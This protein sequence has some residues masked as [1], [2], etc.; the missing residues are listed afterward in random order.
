MNGHTDYQIISDKRGKPAFVVIPYEDFQK[1]QSR[2]KD[3]GSTFPNEV[4]GLHIMEN[5]SLLCAWREHKGLTTENM[6]KRM[7]LSLAEYLEIEQSETIP[8]Q[9]IDK[10]AEFLGID[11]ALLSADE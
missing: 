10:A 2:F 1:I 4:V 8:I 9:Y 6:A 11:P 5:K 7:G 3:S